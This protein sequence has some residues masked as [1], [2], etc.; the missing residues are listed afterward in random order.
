[1]TNVR[2]NDDLSCLF[3]SIEFCVSLPKNNMDLVS[4]FQQAILRLTIEKEILLEIL[5]RDL[6]AEEKEMMSLAF[7]QL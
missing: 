3:S 1:M 2:L 6:T 4:C 5:D 7:T